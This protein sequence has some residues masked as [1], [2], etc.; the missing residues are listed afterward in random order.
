VTE[1]LGGL[2]SQ[3][4]LLEAI[5]NITRETGFPPTAAELAEAVGASTRS[6]HSTLTPA[7]RAGLVRYDEEGRF[8]LG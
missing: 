4:R 8:V 5:E 6:V 1:P 3:A 7:K 2:V